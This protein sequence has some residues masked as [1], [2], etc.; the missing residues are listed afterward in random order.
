M[1]NAKPNSTVSPL[2]PWPPPLK[3]TSSFGV[4]FARLTVSS[5]AP[6]LI[7]MVDVARPVLPRLPETFTWSPALPRLM[8]SSSTAVMA[9]VE[10]PLVAVTLSPALP[11]PDLL[12]SM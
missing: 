12:T 11:T 5:P 7:V 2:G 4:K 9:T 6:P 1:L 8:T 10:L 3:T